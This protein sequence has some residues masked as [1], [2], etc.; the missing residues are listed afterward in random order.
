MTGRIVLFGVTGYTGGL[1]LDALLHRGAKPILAGR[2]G[3]VLGSLA[4]RSGG[5]EYALANAMDTASVAKLLGR[6]DVLISTVGPFE[7]F[8]HAVACAAADSGAHYIDST[9]ELGFVF[10][11]RKQL[12][13]RARES[14]AVMLPAFGYDYVPG[15][16]A[17]ALAAGEG[18]DAVRSIDVGYFATG[19]MLRG[20]SQGT[21]TTVR[22]GLTVPVYR[23]RNHHLVEQRV[24]SAVQSFPVR[25][26][27]KS[28]FLVSGTEVLDLPAVFPGLH[29]VSVYNGL[30]PALSYPAAA[31]S[32]GAA[33]SARIPLGRK[34]IDVATRP[35][36]GAAG[37]PD[38]AERE[39]TRSH[40]VAIARDGAGVTA[41]EVHLEGPSVYSL[42]AALMAWAAQQ[43]AT[44]AGRSAG[45]VGPIDAFGLDALRDGCNEIG[46]SRVGL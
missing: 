22:D 12:D 27:R 17:G 43:L 14:G 23:W 40:V 19:S 4:E 26:R 45:V 10:D 18:G 36:I 37:G 16:L 15:V 32:A 5:L 9:G 3:D 25:G 41:A 39:R 13:D 38:A 46:L 30:F 11:L 44:G 28:A 7:R 1:V 34:L 6:G 20:L 35:L 29:T 33:V 24:G 31:M 8:G 21:R 2:N 42:T